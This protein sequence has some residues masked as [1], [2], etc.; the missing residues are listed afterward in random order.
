VPRRLATLGADPWR[1]INVVE[2]SITASAWRAVGGKPRDPGAS[3]GR[4]SRRR[5]K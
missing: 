2:Q 5:T 4:T 1:A 3:R